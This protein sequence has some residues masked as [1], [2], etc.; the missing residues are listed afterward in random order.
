MWVQASSFS[1]HNRNPSFL[2]KLRF[3]TPVHIYTTDWCG[4]YLP[5]SMLQYDA[6]CYVI[7]I[8]LVSKIDWH[9]SVDIEIYPWPMLLIMIMKDITLN[10][11][12][13]CTCVGVLCRCYS[14]R[15]G[16]CSYGRVTCLQ[17][18][19]MKIVAQ[20]WMILI[21]CAIVYFQQVAYFNMHS[22]MYVCI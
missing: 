10:L 17:K 14:E 16:D 1:S 13:N 3:W 18:K 20:R 15:S 8:L 11:I 4:F 7:L 21:A 12:D 22:H 5:N 9:H 2:L 19:T 6:H